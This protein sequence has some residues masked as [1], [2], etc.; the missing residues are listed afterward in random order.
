MPKADAW[1]Q[2]MLTEVRLR[3]AR[4]R[5]ASWSAADLASELV[6]RIRALPDVADAAVSTMHSGTDGVVDRHRPRQRIRA[7]ARP[8]GVS[9]RLALVSPD[10]GIRD[11]SWA[12]L[13][14]G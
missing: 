1:D 13:F 7:V 12:R 4:S 9:G 5:G 2:S 10:D 6:S 11:C 14:R 8:L 3:V